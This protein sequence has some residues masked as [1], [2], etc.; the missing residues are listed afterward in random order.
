MIGRG[1]SGT[2]ISSKWFRRTAAFKFVEIG[3][4]KFQQTKKDGLKTL[5]EKLPE[6]I[7]I[8]SKKVSFYGHYR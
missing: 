6:M 3:A 8:N 5:D 2:V 1:A 7:S 4:Q